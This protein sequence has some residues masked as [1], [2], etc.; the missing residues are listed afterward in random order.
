[1][2]IAIRF[3]MVYIPEKFAIYKAIMTHF[4][5]FGILT[6]DLVYIPYFLS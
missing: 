6:P 2:R 1:M 3:Y 5:Y 4:R